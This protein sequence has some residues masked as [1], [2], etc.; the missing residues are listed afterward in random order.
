MRNVSKQLKR[1]NSLLLVLSPQS[2]T[3]I[4]GSFSVYV[5]TPQ[6]QTVVV[7][8]VCLFAFVLFFIYIGSEQKKSRKS[9]GRA[10]DS[11]KRERMG[12]VI[13]LS[14]IS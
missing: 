12:D 4:T 2:I 1:W 13:A 3:L 7:G 5:P 8:F 10:L 9:V 14:S 11:R 6:L